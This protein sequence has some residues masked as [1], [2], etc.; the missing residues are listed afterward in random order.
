MQF[1]VICSIQIHA[2]SDHQVHDDNRV[3]GQDF[4]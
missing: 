4:E 1:W 3:D 2:L